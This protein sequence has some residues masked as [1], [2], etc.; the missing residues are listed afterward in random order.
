M[1]SASHPGAT[2]SG[3]GG[4]AHPPSRPSSEQVDVLIGV[5]TR[6]G[7]A[8]RAHCSTASGGSRIARAVRWGDGDRTAG[9]DVMGADPRDASRGRLGDDEGDRAYER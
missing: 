6:Q 4:N 1:V 7:S 2:S 8:P 5:A 3:G 9:R